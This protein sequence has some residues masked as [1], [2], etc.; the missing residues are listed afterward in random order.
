MKFKEALEKNAL[1]RRLGDVQLKYE[2]T[3]WVGRADRPAR[4]LAANVGLVVGT[5]SLAATLA[6]LLTNADNETLAACVLPC[7]LGF[8][9]AAFL[10]QRDRR[11]RAFAADFDA[12]VLRL[13]FSA[14]LTGMPRTLKV[15]FDQVRGLELEEQGGGLKVMTVDFELGEDLFRE[16]LI[17]QVTVAELQQA[18]RVRKMLRAAVGLERPHED[19]PPKPPEVID[20]FTSR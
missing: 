14:P 19:E 20:L 18:E 9:G 10:E 17:A 16:V 4:G 6:G 12:H 11:Q 7:I 5:G 2:T 15:P 8:G 1:P 13:D 3:M